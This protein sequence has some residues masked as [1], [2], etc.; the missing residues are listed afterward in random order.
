[1]KHVKPFWDNQYK[2]LNYRKEIFND[3]YAIEEWRKQGYNN[4]VDSFSGKMANY[5]DALPSWHNKILEWVEEEFQLKDVGCC[6]YR[7]GTNDI[8]PDH[9]DAYNVY[10]KKFNCKTEDVHKILV[11]LE[12]WKSGHYFEYEGEPIINWKAGDWTT[13]VGAIR[14]FAAN[15]GTEYRYTLQ[16]T[17][18]K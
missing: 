13:W 7:M 17:G 12:D 8:I 5:E 2:N 14:H 1:M 3:E 15:I 9:S 16:I 10:T 18:H 11:F 4:D 6:Y